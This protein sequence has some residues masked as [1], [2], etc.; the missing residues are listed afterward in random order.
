LLRRRAADTALCK[1]FEAANISDA[2]YATVL[3]SI[4]CAVCTPALHVLNGL[5]PW[6]K[7]KLWVL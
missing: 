5:L 2:P 4:L 3:K 7:V 1:Q 6:M